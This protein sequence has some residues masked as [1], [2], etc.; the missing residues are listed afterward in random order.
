MKYTL[1]QLFEV[2]DEKKEKEEFYCDLSSGGWGTD[3][4]LDKITSFT[5][6]EKTIISSERNK[7]KLEDKSIMF[8][9]V[10][11]DGLLLFEYISHTEE[12][13]ISRLESIDEATEVIYSESGVMNMFSGDI[14]LIE[15]GKRKRFYVKDASG[16]I[17]KWSDMESIK[18][19]GDKI[20]VEWR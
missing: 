14:I 2:I 15:D 6:N 7:R 13:T 20:F 5:P 3:Y 12:Y 19:R 18:Q 17:L 8:Q 10:E 9:Q 16:T 11:V 4:Y 1:Q